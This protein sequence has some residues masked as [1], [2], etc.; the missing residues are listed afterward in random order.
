[1]FYFLAVN[2]FVHF[3]HKQQVIRQQGS[4]LFLV[5]MTD[6]RRALFVIFFQM[7][8]TIYNFIVWI[9][10]TPLAVIALIIGGILMMISAGNPN[11]MGTGK[12]ILY[13]AIIG[14]ALVFC[15]Y[16]IN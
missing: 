14:L 9:L 12:K 13:S 6:K 4:L 1:L 8:T 10:A 7:L 3:W 15:S 11:L 16:L 2:N 5:A